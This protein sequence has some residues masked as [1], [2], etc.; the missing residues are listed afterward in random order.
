M[1]NL[2]SVSSVLEMGRERRVVRILPWYIRPREDASAGGVRFANKMMM[3]AAPMVEEAEMMD[4]A[5]SEAKVVRRVMP[6]VS[7]GTAS[8]RWELGKRTVRAGIP[9]TVI[10][11]KARWNAE[12]YRNI[13][14]NT[15][16]VSYLAADIN[17]P[18]P[19]GMSSA[20]TTVMVDDVLVGTRTMSIMG[21]KET[22][23]F[24]QDPYVTAKMIAHD[25]QGGKNGFIIGKKQTYNW[26]WDIEVKNTHKEP[27]K[28][29]IE[30]A[31]PQNQD[32]RIGLTIKSEPPADREKDKLRWKLS[33]KTG[34]TVIKHSVAIEAPDD[35]RLQRGR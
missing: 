11:D 35:M 28:V 13:R 26:N 5:V 2:S 20:L 17:L 18:E 3:A 24:G 25:Q 10:L 22:L 21:Q 29:V 1:V 15:N 12:F 23:F 32:K 27:V 34:V 33:A 14:P 30:D 16:T 8:A 4:N 6:K 7:E 19:A 9:C 31:L